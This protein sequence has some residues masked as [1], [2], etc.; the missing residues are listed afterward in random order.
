MK[1]NIIETENYLLIVSDEEIKAGNFYLLIPEN[2]VKLSR[3]GLPT[4]IREWA[5]II[6]HLPLNNS[7]VL[8]GVDLLPPIEDNIEQWAW[9]NPCLSRSDVYHLFE[10]VFKEKVFEGYY[11][12]SASKQVHQFKEKVRKLAKE[13]AEV[14]K[15]KYK[16]TEEDLTRAFNIGINSQFEST[17]LKLNKDESFDR[18]SKNLLKLIQS[19][20]QPKMP[21]GFECE[22]ERIY[23]NP[24][25]I[26]KEYD[27]DD[28]LIERKT[29]TNSQGQTVLVGKYIY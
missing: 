29:T 4:N 3:S 21:V 7:P 9:D 17:E 8:E 25:T 5:K 11:K 27:F 16:Y 23:P 13:K 24:Q 6:A 22:V 2:I 15:E 1:H 20:Q 14:V 18:H 19:L 26:S 28:I 12:I 10:E